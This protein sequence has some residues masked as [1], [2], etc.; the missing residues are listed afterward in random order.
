MG[1]DSFSGDERLKNPGKGDE[2]SIRELHS[3]III[4]AKGENG[5]TQRENE[6]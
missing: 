1:G 2:K 4:A 6:E 5:D 3:E